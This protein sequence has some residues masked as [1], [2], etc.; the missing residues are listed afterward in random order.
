MTVSVPEKTL[1]HWASQYVTYRYR[2]KAGIWWPARGEDVDVRWLPRVPGKVVQ[3]EIKTTTVTGANTHEVRVDLG[4]LWDYCHRPLG[5]QP[6]YVFPQP[7]WRGTLEAVAVASGRPVTELAF[8]RSGDGWWF[9]DWMI[10]LTTA[11]VAAVLSTELAGHGSSTRGATA[12]LVQYHL[13]GLRSAPVETWGNRVPA[14]NFRNWRDF[15]DDLEG[16]GFDG[17]PQMI[18]LPNWI[19]DHRR[20]DRAEVL[21]FLRLFKNFDSNRDP[22]ERFELVT[23]ESDPDG[24]FRQDLEPRRSLRDDEPA[25]M[26]TEDRRQVVFL[27][28]AA[29]R[30]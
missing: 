25:S 2:S 13:Q 12:R 29:L 23:L 30:L 17:W 19:G 26:I 18:R 14:P 27:S 20:F 22:R 6:Y 24:G 11:Q 1:E 16:C 8:S 5:R 15:W 9:A 21:D 3:L 4:Q 28:L 7:D 10:V